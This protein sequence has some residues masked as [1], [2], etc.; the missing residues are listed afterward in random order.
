M[1]WGFLGSGASEQIEVSFTLPSDIFSGLGFNCTSSK[2]CDM[3]VG[4]GGGDNPP[5]LEDYFEVEG[6]RAPHTDVSLGGT[7]DLSVVSLSYEDY[8]TTVRFR[9]LLDTK[10]VWDARIY[11]APTDMVYAWCG[12]SFCVD[13]ESAHTPGDWE[14]FNVDL[15]GKDSMERD[16]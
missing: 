10:D 11:K 4:N 12:G 7:Y 5:Y 15:S 13:K 16:A 8:A 14:I 3:I 9:R 1:S 2:M 6:D